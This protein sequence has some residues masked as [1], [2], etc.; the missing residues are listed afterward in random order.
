[1][2]S[3]RKNSFQ[4]LTHITSIYPPTDIS[5]DG[6]VNFEIFFE[7]GVIWWLHTTVSG[8]HWKIH[9]RHI[10]HWQENMASQM[11][12]W[13]NWSTTKALL[14]AHWTSCAGYWTA[15]SKIYVN[16]HLDKLKLNNLRIKFQNWL[17][18]RCIFRKNCA[19]VPEERSAI[20]LQTEQS[21]AGWLVTIGYSAIPARKF[22]AICLGCHS[23]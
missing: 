6:C 8:K 15:E 18:H 20:P 10:T 7:N 22:K 12:P 23:A 5:V 16:T 13:Q 19:S 3:I 4:K 9:R 14:S 21:S 11:V 2:Q 17:N 1:M